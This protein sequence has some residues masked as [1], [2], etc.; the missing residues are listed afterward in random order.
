MALDQTL[1]QTAIHAAFK[2][3]KDVVR[4]A[5]PSQADAVQEQILT[6]LAL[7]LTGAITAFVKSGDVT[8]VTVQVKDSG[9]NVI[10][11]GAQTG[12]GKIG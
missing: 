1:L 7:D 9:A 8:G 3:A 6:Q 12:T 2:K 5:D 11:T 4:P 10:G